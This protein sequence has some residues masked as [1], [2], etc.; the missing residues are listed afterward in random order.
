MTDQERIAD[1]ESTLKLLWGAVVEAYLQGDPTQDPQSKVFL[2]VDR[3]I[4]RLGILK[5]TA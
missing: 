1:L 5:V 4:R 3:E 2:K